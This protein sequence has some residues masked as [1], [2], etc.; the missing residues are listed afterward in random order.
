MLY[1][2]RVVT[3]SVDIIIILCVKKYINVCICK[4]VCISHVEC[5]IAEINNAIMYKLRCI[6]ICYLFE[7]SYNRLNNNNVT[8]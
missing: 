2:V 8:S 1:C 3:L 7:I 4:D 6:F 5:R